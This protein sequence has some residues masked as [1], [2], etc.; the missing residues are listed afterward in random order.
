MDK[1]FDMPTC[2]WHISAC[3]CTILQFCS[4]S[5]DNF[6]TKSL[7]CKS[8]IILAKI[9]HVY[10]CVYGSEFPIFPDFYHRTPDF[11]LRIKSEIPVGPP[12]SSLD[13]SWHFLK[14][15][16][17]LGVSILKKWSKT[18]LLQVF[19]IHIFTFSTC[20]CTCILKQLLKSVIMF[21]SCLSKV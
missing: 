19:K 9:I 16:H 6:F 11:L 17:T 15:T 1:L 20:I 5:F 8:L 3:T 4:I 18:D 7:R 2:N 12:L 21:F 14:Y 10:T 13:A